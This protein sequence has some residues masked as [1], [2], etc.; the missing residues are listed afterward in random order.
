MRKYYLLVDNFFTS[1]QI[2]KT[3]KTLR[4]VVQF[5]SRFHLRHKYIIGKKI[6]PKNML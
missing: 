6:R 4:L 3:Y 1:Q 5:D 2:Q